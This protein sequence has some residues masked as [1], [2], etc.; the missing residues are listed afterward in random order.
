MQKEKLI[1][2]S[3]DVE[4]FD[5]PLEYGI[6]IS[7]DEQ[8]EV[9]NRGT[10]SIIP[11]LEHHQIA[12]TLYTTANYA[13]HF[14]AQ[15]NALAQHHEIASHTFYHSS[16]AVEDLLLSKQKLEEISQ[17]NVYGLRMPRMQKIAMQEV[18]RA[19]Y[20]YDSSINPTFLPGRYNNLHLPRTL[21]QDENVYRLPTSVTPHLRIPLFWLAFKNLPYAA[22]KFLA[23]QTLAKD[24]YLC[25]YFH[26][27]EFTDINAYHLPAFVKRSCG[28]PLQD[29]LDRLITDL[30]K[31]G[32]FITTETLI[33]EKA[34][35]I[36]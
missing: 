4:E 1:L 14:P 25:L 2:L 8:F 19:G 18:K 34:P 12:T 11:I 36:K 31:E 33:K 29:K 23:V 30:K 10:E 16:F 3:F 17:K 24:G 32:N 5:L 15:I 20:L 7:T 9:G 22:F 21:Y 28:K 26:P 27:W 6:N 13:M 35:L